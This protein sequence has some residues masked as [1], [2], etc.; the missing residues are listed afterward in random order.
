MLQPIKKS[1]RKITAKGKIAALVADGFQEK[2]YFLP[3]VALQRAGFKVEALS[4]ACRLQPF[5]PAMNKRY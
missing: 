4:T 5:R 1:E 3:K 2:E